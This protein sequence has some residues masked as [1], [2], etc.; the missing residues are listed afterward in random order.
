MT[1][2][3]MIAKMNP[4]MLNSA[5]NQISSK[6]TPEQRKNMENAIKNTNTEQFKSQ[7]A[8]MNFDDIK[9]ELNKNPNMIKEL[10]KNKDLVNQ[11]NNIITKK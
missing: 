8:N 7:L 2:E 3:E 9:R 11:I 1:I 10:S 6:L 5:L 4:Q